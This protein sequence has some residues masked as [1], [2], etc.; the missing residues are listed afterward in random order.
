[1]INANDSFGR[2]SVNGRPV[3]SGVVRTSLVYPSSGLGPDCF[4]NEVFRLESLL[5]SHQALLE[6]AAHEQAL[7]SLRRQIQS[8]LQR[9]Y[10]EGVL[11]EDLA[12]SD[13][14]LTGNSYH[15]LQKY[16]RLRR[17]EQFRMLAESSF[18]NPNP[19]LRVGLGGHIL[20]ANRAGEA[21]V[22][23]LQH[24]LGSSLGEWLR[25]LIGR[26]ISQKF[27][28][29]TEVRCDGRDFALTV[30]PVTDASYVYIYGHDVSSLKEA[31]RTAEILALHDPLT[32]LPNRVYFRQRFD[33]IVSECERSRSTLAVAF[34]DLDNFKQVND[35]FGHS[36]GDRTLKTIA[37]FLRESLEQSETVARWGGDEFVVL[38]PDLMGRDAQSRC[39]RLLSQVPRW[40]VD[41][42][43][44]LVTLSYGVACFPLDAR[45]L[46]QLLHVADQ[47]LMMAKKE[48]S[49]RRT[50][51]SI[52]GLDVLT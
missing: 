19:I 2:S 7:L 20:D 9:L 29:R 1:M 42:G 36:V 12:T 41:E 22:D 10:R 43:G 33:Q 14:A 47:K 18:E 11:P 48:R 16:L 39:E 28:A 34:V 8:E 31:S 40:T 44:C 35:R 4:Q 5:E 23:S 45:N 46:E 13:S 24:E 3:C 52:A 32:G 15:K 51:A 6:Q 26:A 38:F 30:T 37:G 49:S 50:G 21:F 25:G 27:T 17:A